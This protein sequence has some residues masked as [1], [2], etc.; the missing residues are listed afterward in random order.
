MK[1]RGLRRLGLAYMPGRGELPDHFAVAF[2]GIDPW[3]VE[4]EL[5]THTEGWQAGGKAAPKPERVGSRLWRVTYEQ[6]ESQAGPLTRHATIDEATEGLRHAVRNAFA[7]CR[8]IGSDWSEWF[9]RAL[10]QLENREP[11]IAFHPDMLPDRG[12]PP[13]TRQLVAA[14]SHAWVF[15][16]MGSWNDLWL[17]DNT[18]ARSTGVSRKTCSRL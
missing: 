1:Q 10:Q 5:G 15:G 4:A 13:P 7:F 8:R 6:V 12:I 16:G 11:D 9:E 18:L 17:A 2:A 14:A 3:I